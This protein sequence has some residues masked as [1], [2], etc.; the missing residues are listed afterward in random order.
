MLTGRKA[1]WVHG[2]HGSVSG[3]TYLPFYKR[4]ST[5]QAYDIR[6]GLVESPVGR[7]QRSVQ[8]TTRLVRAIYSRRGTHRLFRGGRD[9]RLAGAGSLETFDCRRDLGGVVKCKSVFSPRP[10]NGTAWDEVFAAVA[11]QGL[12]CAHMNMVSAGLESMPQDLPDEVIEHVRKGLGRHGLTLCGLSATF[13]AIHPDRALREE[14]IRRFAVL[15]EAAHL[16]GTD[17]VTL[18]TGTR[19]PDSM[20]SHHPENDTPEAWRDLLDTLGQLLEKAEEFDLR[21]GIEP[22]IHNVV[23]C[24]EKAS[25]LLK[26]LASPRLQII[27]DPANLFHLDDLDRMEDVLKRAFDLLGP[28]IAMAHAKDVMPDPPLRYGAAG[29][30]AVN[31]PLYIQLLRDAEYTG[32]LV[33]HGL[34]EEDVPQSVSYLRSMLEETSK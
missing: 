15:A 6:T 27:M 31:W 21:L 32:D 25:E 13:N 30:G 34:G 16:L 12:S 23:N 26:A 10:F 22:E 28:H 17:F 19:D 2:E 18:C 14:G 29:Q 24:P 20:W 1:L 33:L 7:G 5:V 9:S 8:E 4:A 3:R 11:E